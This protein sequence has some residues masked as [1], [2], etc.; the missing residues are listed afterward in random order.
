MN[1]KTTTIKNVK[2]LTLVAMLIAMSAVGAMIK[3]Y[4]TVAFDSLPG[5]FASLYFGGYIGAIVISLGHIFTA[6][7]SGFPLGIPNHIIIAVSMAVCAYFYSLAYKKFNSYVAVAVGTILN[8]PVATL[9][10]VPQYGWGFFIQMVLPLT[11]ASFANVL[12]ASIIYKTV[13]KMIKR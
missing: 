6:L 10:F 12:L 1:T 7:T 3:V 2:T 13:L 11:I 5:Y 4:N 8:G 9:I